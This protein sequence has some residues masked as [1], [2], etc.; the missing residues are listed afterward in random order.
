MANNFYD[1][2]FIIFREDFYDHRIEMMIIWKSKEKEWMAFGW[3]ELL[4]ILCALRV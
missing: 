3:I 1:L 4:S 2:I